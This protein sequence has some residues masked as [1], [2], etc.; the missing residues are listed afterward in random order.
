MFGGQVVKSCERAK[1]STEHFRQMSVRPLPTLCKWEFF[2]ND[3][4]AHRDIQFWLTI[5]RMRSTE[6]NRALMSRYLRNDVCLIMKN[7]TFEPRIENNNQHSELPVGAFPFVQHAVLMCTL[8]LKTGPAGATALLFMIAIVVAR[9]SV[10]SLKR[11]RGKCR[12]RLIIS[13]TLSVLL[14]LLS[15]SLCP[16]ICASIPG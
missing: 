12:H 11:T 8:I 2:Y 4:I 3:T 13:E 10:S 5:N 16:Q 1:A 15:S 14:S 9:S 7:Y 6:Y